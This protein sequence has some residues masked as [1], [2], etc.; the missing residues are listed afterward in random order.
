MAAS[1]VASF[2]THDL[3]IVLFIG[4]LVLLVSVAAVRFANR[5]GM[6]TLVLYLGIGLI[7]GEAGFGIGFENPELTQ[8]L[9]YSALALILAEGGISTRWSSIRRSVAPAALLATLGVLVSVFVV[10]LF[11]VL[12]LGKSWTIALL[13]G[14]IVTSTD[15][16]AVFSVLK[17]ISLPRR[18]TGV[19]EAESGFNDAPVVLL[20]VALAD[21]ATPGRTAHAW[22]VVALEAAG[23]L[24]GGAI[25]GLALGF[26]FAW[27]SRRTVPGSSGL[28]SLG[29]LAAT[30]L[31][32]AA[33]SLVHTSGFIAVYLAALVLG[34]SNLPHRQAVHGFVQSVGWLAQIGLF[35]L[36][37]LLASPSRLGSQ[38]VPAVVVGLVLLLIARPLSVFASLT[39]FRFPWREQA[40]LSW[41]G[42][43][44]AVPVVLATVP[45]TV[46]TPNTEWIFDL[47]FVLVLVFTLV[48]VMP[49]P[50]IARTLGIAEAAQVVDLDVEATP[51][52]E[53]HADVLQL[54]V[55]ATS[56]LAGVE[57]QELRL[58]EGAN[59]TLIVRGERGFVPGPR[60]V[61][62]RGDQLLLVT[63]ARA[64]D[65]A[66][67][68]VRS[69]S[70]D[71]RMAGWSTPL[72]PEPDE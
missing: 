59:V 68:R 54:T 17:R 19:L 58:P 60:T 40:F 50:W 36:L 24:V 37:G 26:L 41:A 3:A 16:A 61:I 32:Y 45:L 69:V 67:R 6:P 18:L 35:V 27:L 8:V 39:W 49:M 55:G 25:I 64:R 4:A 20:V 12:F 52:E 63:T 44:G 1:A 65:L 70:R 28:F 47:V 5:S 11:V 53:L 15:A 10:G 22:W 29:I 38:I 46:G 42:L 62:R 57:I 30:I 56:R 9:G 21:A 14:A 34:N 72:R 7:M 31:A 48:Q 51:L 71:G 66:V 33:A 13:L 23:E 43:R 2:T